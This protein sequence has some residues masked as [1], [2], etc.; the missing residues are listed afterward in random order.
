MSK[1]PLRGFRIAVEG[2]F[3]EPRTPTALQRWVENNGGTF[4]G[5]VEK[6]LTHLVCTEDAWKSKT[7][8]GTYPSLLNHGVTR[9]GLKLTVIVPLSSTGTKDQ[10]H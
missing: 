8:K 2:D 4:C 9:R 7:M 5:A 3:G 10:T 6:D 1:S